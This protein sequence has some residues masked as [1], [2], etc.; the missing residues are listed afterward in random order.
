MLCGFGVAGVNPGHPIIVKG[1]KN[2]FVEAIENTRPLTN[3]TI[4]LHVKFFN[5][6]FNSGTFNIINFR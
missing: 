4:F 2:C 5:N 3:R 6:I 1:R